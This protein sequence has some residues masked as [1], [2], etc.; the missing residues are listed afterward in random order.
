MYNV[1]IVEDDPMVMEINR[2]FI[3]SIKYIKVTKVFSNGKKAWDYISK[4]NPV[5]LIILDIY[6]PEMNG[7][8]LLNKLRASGNNCAVIPVTA[9]NEP[10]SLENILSYSVVDYLVK[11][12]KKE[13]LEQAIERFVYYKKLT[14][15]KYPLSQADINKL[16]IT[17]TPEVNRKD[18]KK[19]EPRTLE[20][21][22]NYLE[23]HRGEQLTAKMVS[24]N[25][26]LSLVTV[27]R[28]MNHLV[29]EK[30]IQSSLNYSTGGK[31]AVV[32]TMC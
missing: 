21:I 7:F 2:E 20:L 32:Y 24:D 16:F 23:T 5:D 26:G 17:K 28:Y 30:N 22:I 12:F 27:R 10:E 18:E 9:A 31:P 29:K 6:M 19:L 11:P 3:E 15:K 4:G 14:E 25:V 8:Q 13:R 1:I